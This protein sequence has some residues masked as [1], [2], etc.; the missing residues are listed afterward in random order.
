MNLSR[1]ILLITVLLFT[2]PLFAQRIIYSEPETDDTRRLNFEVIGKVSGNFLIYKNLRSKNWIAVYDNDMKLIQSAEHNYI[3][4]ERLINVDFFP[5]AEHVYMI[6]QYQRKNV[7]YCNAVKVNGL[8]E[9][10][11]VRHF[12]S[13]GF[14]QQKQSLGYI[15]FSANK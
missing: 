11:S 13:R 8:G 4:D 15:G 3:P 2:L 6:Y 7:I 9:K 10:M 1:V 12:S 14:N 5:Y